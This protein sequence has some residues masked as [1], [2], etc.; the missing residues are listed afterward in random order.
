MGRCGVGLGVLSF[1]NGN[2][3]VF[4]HGLFDES[5]FFPFAPLISRGFAP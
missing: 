1:G 5:S 3:I 4:S 2:N